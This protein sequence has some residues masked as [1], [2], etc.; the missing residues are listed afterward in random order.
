MQT[1]Q[2]ESHAVGRVDDDVG[3][4]RCEEAPVFTDS[5]R[6]VG[7][8]VGHLQKSVL[9]GFLVEQV[10]V[11]PESGTVK[12]RVER[13]ERKL[14]ILAERLLHRV[15]GRDASREG[16]VSCT[17]TDVHQERGARLLSAVV[18]DVVS[19]QELDTLIDENALRNVILDTIS[20]K[21]DAPERNAFMDDSTH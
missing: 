9:Q 6:V 4:K 7:E 11:V 1:H 20:T 15:R 19:L 5:I 14:I 18:G 13:I 2:L 12:R 3:A 21:A 17:E 10:R 16:H 8:R